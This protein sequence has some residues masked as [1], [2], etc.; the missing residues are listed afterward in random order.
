MRQD[1]M[2]S[3]ITRHSRQANM[4]GLSDI[5]K[6]CNDVHP[7]YK[8]ERNNVYVNHSAYAFKR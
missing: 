8:L 4:K 5:S 1:V 3:R 7:A 2:N 6:R